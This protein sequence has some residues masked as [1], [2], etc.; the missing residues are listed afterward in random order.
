MNGRRGKIADSQHRAVLNLLH[1]H[2]KAVSHGIIE[3]HGKSLFPQYRRNDHILVYDNG[4]RLHQLAVYK[5]AHKHHSLTIGRHGQVREVNFRSGSNFVSLICFAGIAVNK[6]DRMRFKPAVNR[7]NR[8]VPQ[9]SEIGAFKQGPFNIPA[10]KVRILMNG[11]NREFVPVKA[12]VIEHGYGLQRF[13]V[14]T[15]NERDR[16][17]VL[18]IGSVD[19]NV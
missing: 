12:V 18:L 13:T 17:R 19:Y 4:S 3:S 1:G 15:V 11:R 8:H 7:C 9:H 6:R 10:D 2:K 16:I 5:P 14:V